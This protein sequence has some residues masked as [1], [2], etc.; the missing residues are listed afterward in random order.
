MLGII[1]ID[2]E[3]VMI[4]MRPLRELVSVLPPS[5]ERYPLTFSM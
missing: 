1:R 5:V 4:A 2:P 3:V